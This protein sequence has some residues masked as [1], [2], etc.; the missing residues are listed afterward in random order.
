MLVG[1]SPQVMSDGDQGLQSNDDRD[2][3]VRISSEPVSPLTS[4]V[5]NDADASQ[6]RHVTI[7]ICHLQYSARI[8]CLLS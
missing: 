7:I 6:D 8:A 3:G 2:S 1:T 5:E 4:E